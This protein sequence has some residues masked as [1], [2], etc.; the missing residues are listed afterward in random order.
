MLQDGTMS[1]WEN[2]TL[3]DSVQRLFKAWLAVVVELSVCEMIFQ[4]LR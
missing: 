1:D 2:D 3:S 4:I